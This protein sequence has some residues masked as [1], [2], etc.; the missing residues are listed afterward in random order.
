MYGTLYTGDIESVFVVTV[1]FLE[2]IIEKIKISSFD[3]LCARAHTHTHTH[4]SC[5]LSTVKEWQVAFFLF[6]TVIAKYLICER[7]TPK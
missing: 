2:K 4:T 5:S 6:S 3:S 1:I 7:G